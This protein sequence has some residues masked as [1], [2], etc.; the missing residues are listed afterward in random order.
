MRISICGVDASGKTSVME[1]LA[2]AAAGSSVTVATLRAPQYHDG[3]RLDVG[4]LS[5]ELEALGTRA[6]QEGLP[7]LKACCL[8]LAISLYGDAQK[9]VESTTG[10]EVL[11]R[12]RDPIVDSLTYSGP[13]LEVL[14][15][16]PRPID[17]RYSSA[18]IER[19]IARVAER[20]NLDW[21]TSTLVDLPRRLQVLFG[22]PAV[23]LAAVLPK[24]CNA[25]I[26]DVVVHLRVG[27]RALTERLRRR[28]E[29]RAHRRG[30]FHEEQAILLRLQSA[31]ADC[32]RASS[33]EWMTLDTDDTTS[34]E[35]ARDLVDRFARRSDGGA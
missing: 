30:E 35:I 13:Y 33:S 27:P 20:A 29:A 24:I 1:D 3:H 32:R 34:R 14:S 31:M 25:G 5:E 18:S 22:R 8:F 2:Q 6:D 17:P 4:P 23:E 15:R 21:P 9:E 7:T 11:F 16:D 12:E 28:A 10:C 26:A 19:H